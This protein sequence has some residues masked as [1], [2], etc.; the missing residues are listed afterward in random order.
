MKK[1]LNIIC[2]YAFW[3]CDNLRTIEIPIDS[4]LQIIEAFAFMDTSIESI[5]IPS[6][7]IELEEGC[8]NNTQNLTNIN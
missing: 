6:N 1:R 3:C 4:E 5:T 7:L 2:E 8:L